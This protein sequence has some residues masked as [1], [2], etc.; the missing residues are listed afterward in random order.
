M[1]INFKDG[2]E[3]EKFYRELKGL[4]K[5]KGYDAYEDYWDDF[6]DLRKATDPYPKYLYPIQLIYQKHFLN[7]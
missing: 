2:K 6:L 7:I 1:I 5:R 4:K 3:I